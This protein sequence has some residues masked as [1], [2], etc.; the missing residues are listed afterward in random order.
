MLLWRL[1]PSLNADV[2]QFIKEFDN[3]QAL[4]VA[5]VVTSTASKLTPGGVTPGAVDKAATS[6]VKTEYPSF[7]KPAE[8]AS[9]WVWKKINFKDEKSLGTK[10][11]TALSQ[12]RGII[13]QFQLLGVSDAE[14]KIAAKQVAM[15]KKTI[16]DYTTELQKIA[17]K[18]YPQFADRFKLDPTLTTYDIASPVINMVAKTL[19]IDPKAVKMDHPVVLAY[20]RSA[21]ADGKGVAP[22]YYDLLLKTKQLPDYQKTKQANDEARDSAESLGNALG[23]GI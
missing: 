8:F 12:V 18:E 22:S 4:Q 6:T 3:E 1:Q 14:A 23:Y 16:A 19:E 5:K 10:S 7:F 20:T 15:G 13:D 21:G 11:L 2:A 9:D 17:I